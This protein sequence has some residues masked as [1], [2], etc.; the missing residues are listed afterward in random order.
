MDLDNDYYSSRCK[1]INGLWP[2][3][4]TF[5]IFVGV[6]HWSLNGTLFL[7]KEL[8]A[9]VGVEMLVPYRDDLFLYHFPQIFPSF[10][11]QV[12]GMAQNHIQFERVLRS[13]LHYG[14]GLTMEMLRALDTHPKAIPCKSRNHLY[15]SLGCQ[16]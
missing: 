14:E 10:D 15:K 11:S 8:F 16:V 12:M 2:F 4:G 6:E 3:T 5:M 1:D 9:G 7:S 13:P